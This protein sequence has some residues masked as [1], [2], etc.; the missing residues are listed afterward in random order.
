MLKVKKLKN[1]TGKIVNYNDSF[2]GEI[3]FDKKILDISKKDFIDNKNVIIPGFIDLHCH[4]GGGF[5]TM[6]GLESIV[7]MSN[8]HLFKGTTSILP[9]TLTDTLE[10][11]FKALNGLFKFMNKNKFK[12]NI[13]GTHLEGPFIN[14][15]KLGAQPPKS[16]KPNIGF[17]ESIL[18]IAPVTVVT[19]APELTG[20]NDL[21][22][23]LNSK[24]IKVQIGHSLADYKCCLKIMN[25]NKIGITHLFNAMSGCDHRNPGVATAALNHAEYAE[26]ICDLY[27]VDQANIHLAH[28]CIP[29]LYAITDAISACGMPDGKYDFANT[30][31][32]KREGRAL[33]DGT[34]LAGSVIN[35]HNTFKNLIKIN[36]SLKQAVAMTSYHAAKYLNEKD[37]GK[38]EKGFCANLV[39][40][41]NHYDIKQVYFYGQLVTPV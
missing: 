6:A 34:T 14:P 32:E 24:N 21:I 39:V 35:M 13:I 40:L 30:I 18:K 10:H 4:G 17:I 33:I 11:T 28:K 20:A 22:R 12:S 36:F 25:T 31:I 26:I 41:D 16:Q 2:F 27:H 1:I 8:Y 23:Y 3:S 19:L 38:I 37:K 5:D 9:T 29:G 15:N 7:K